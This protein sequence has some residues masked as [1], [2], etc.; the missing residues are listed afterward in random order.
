M[1]DDARGPQV[2]PA[3]AP[4]RFGVL[5][6][7][8]VNTAGGP[9]RL[10]GPRER[11][12][13]GVLLV[14]RGTVVTVDHLIDA[15][16]DERMPVTA[17]RQ[18]QNCVSAL[19]RQLAANGAGRSV[20][21]AD[22][23]G[24]RVG[25]SPQDLDL[26][27]FETRVATGRGLALAGEHERAVTELRAALDLWRGPALAGLDGR[28]I[29]STAAR[30]EEQRLAVTEEFIDLELSLGR[31]RQVIAELTAL[32]AAQPLRERL[33]GQLMLALYRSGRQADALRRYVGTCAVLREEL[34]VDPGRRLQELHRAILSADRALL[35][36]P[37]EAG[38]GPAEQAARGSSGL[39]PAQL[40]VDV[41]HFVGRTRHLKELDELLANDATVGIC[42]VAGMAGVGKT[43]L[44]VH[45]AHGV[46]VRFPDGQLYL[47]LRG[48]GPDGSAMTAG[49]ALH[50]LLSAL[51]VPP[52][53]MPTGIDA[54]AGLYRSLVA[55]RR[56]LIVLDNAC[57]V[58]QVA[59]LLPGA[60]GSLVLVTS[61]GQLVDLV[62]G[63]A[64]R[65]LILHPLPIG[66]A[67]QLLTQ[68]LGQDRTTAEPGAV[69]EIIRQ[70]AGL[71]LALAIVAARATTRPTFPLR[72][73]ADGLAEP[74]RGLDVFA[75][76]GSTVDVRATF[77]WSYGQ[78]SAD[79]ARLFRWLGL[80]F[81][82]DLTAPAAAS[83]AGEPVRQVRLALAELTA[84]NLTTEIVPGRYGAHDLLRAYAAELVQVE[85][86]E[87]GR[88]AATRRLLD[89]YLLSA[90]RADRSLYE[91]RHP[92][93]PLAPGPG[94]DPEPPDGRDEAFAWFTAEHP[95]LLAAVRGA[96][97]AG[98]DEHAWQLGWALATF[99]DFRGDGED[100]AATQRL[101]L[102]AAQRLGDPVGQ[103]HGHRGLGRANLRLGRAAEA[104]SHLR[105]ALDRFAD[106]DDPVG[107][108]RT[109]LDLA[110]S[111][112][113]DDDHGRT[114]HH[115]QRALDHF[116]AAG[117][118]P[119]Q[120]DAMIGIGRNAT[121]LGEHDLGLA[122]CRQAVELSQRTD[123]RHSE[124]RAWDG[125]GCTYQHLGDH[126]QAADCHR[127]AHGLFRTVGAR[128]CEAWALVHLGDAQRAGGDTAAARAVWRGAEDILDD[129]M[130]PHVARVRERLR[131]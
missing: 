60:P 19:R 119:G 99:H 26:D 114:L 113:V 107:Q 68:R 100:W 92:I 89:H 56:L 66:E 97:A 104:L 44:A 73:V 67:Q 25:L 20:I 17:R 55:G 129:L 35:D 105:S 47:N 101:A 80:H 116:R 65:L 103:A 127:R 12:I 6:E 15:V 59:P 40:P 42:V 50:G 48:H 2:T 75:N 29:E 23:P 122:I 76:G 46:T 126:G 45:W 57:S 4:A 109:Q 88:L 3:T 94:V 10:A 1:E 7:V 54:Q 53:G 90:Y 78:L 51:G 69:R 70:C 91:H 16:W 108:A 87:A 118:L 11:K 71:P 77:S 64:A 110:W 120:A 81:G 58:G 83:L 117:H 37:A 22:G 111:A 79:A 61:R 18:V 41:A 30:L 31:H 39:V 84:A 74:G 34:G 106:L 86:D 93:T 96:V 49:E 32:V 62:A 125:L 27:L 82:P 36:A 112:E 43:T 13:L 33:V 9:L 98:L 52:A 14:G 24:Y 5:G 95:V 85:V 131:R 28:I 38:T 63:G 102:A 21:L 115:Y 72:A 8:Q 130:H 128:Y 121:L 123:Q 124:A